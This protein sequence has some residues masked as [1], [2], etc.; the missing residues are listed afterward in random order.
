L[1][2]GGRR[3]PRERTGEERRQALIE[4]E[5]RR[6]GN[7]NWVPP[8]G[9]P[10]SSAPD[11]VLGTPPPETPAGPDPRLQPARPAQQPAPAPARPAE[12]AA[13]RQ[14]RAAEPQSVQRA[15]RPADP[16]PSWTSPAAP[17]PAGEDDGGWWDDGDLHGDD[18]G[19]PVA[20]WPPPLDAPAAAPQPQQPA[21][22]SYP[23]SDEPRLRPAQPAQPAQPRKIAPEPPA[24]PIAEAFDLPDHRQIA[25]HRRR[26][27]AGRAPRTVVS[28]PGD[29]DM[30]GSLTPKR[31]RRRRIAS[32]IIILFLALIAYS[33]WK[34]W[35]PGKGG[36]TGQIEVVIPKGSTASEVATKL[37]SAGVVD[38]ARLFG[39]RALIAG[40]REDL[41]AGKYSLKQDMSYG[42]A[43]TAISGGAAVPVNLVDV[44]IP[45]GL[46]I[47]EIAKRFKDNGIV[48]DYGATAKRLLKKHA[49]ELHSKY[50]MPLNSKSLEGFLFPATYQ[51]PEG[52]TA[53]D[54]IERQLTAFDQ[55]I[56]SVS[57][58]RA[59][60]AQLSAYDVIT[61][62]SMVEREARI[63]RERPIIA[64][65]IWNRLKNGMP[66]G[67]DATFRYASND[68][69]NP[70]KQS[71]LDKDGPYNSRTRTGLPATPIGNPGLASIQAAAAPSKV[72]YLYFV[73]KPNRCG[74][75]A[76][77]ATA[78]KFAE[79][80]AKYNAARNAAGKSPVT[81]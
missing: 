25:V 62:A 55:N 67:I 15:A 23:A 61:I 24:Q 1:F 36:G 63:T 75:H 60:K 71:E 6:T 31:S 46:S 4:R 33:Q 38:S 47:R 12:P 50:G 30:G 79:D 28:P 68:W 34:L 11:A 44:P 42:A 21:A 65:V 14:P 2:G 37:E 58:T 74:E 81:C 5:R 78:E 18:A 64:A 16:D 35:Q 54:L 13:P 77:A 41:V 72:N 43:L 22:R 29:A 49:A 70:I 9:H 26:S 39:L 3:D 7:P 80:S 10:L 66:T 56:G 45:E 59:K 8:A 52:F 27:I 53:E 48:N 73:V 69:V 76:F 17:A 40:K 32:L 51:M 20:A 19:R 57:L